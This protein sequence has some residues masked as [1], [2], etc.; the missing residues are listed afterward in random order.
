[1]FDLGFIKI[2]KFRYPLTPQLKVFW[3]NLTKTMSFSCEI[4]DGEFIFLLHYFAI[5]V[6]IEQISMENNHA[7]GVPPLIYTILYSFHSPSYFSN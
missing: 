3:G 5:L 1:M 4:F 7:I 2:N 6:E